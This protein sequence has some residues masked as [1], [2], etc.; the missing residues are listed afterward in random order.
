M[1]SKTIYGKS[2]QQIFELMAKTLMSLKLGE[3]SIKAVIALLPEPQ[4]RWK[5]MEWMADRKETHEPVEGEILEQA[6]KMSKKR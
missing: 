3:T 1:S 2:A 6:L 5:L 4:Q